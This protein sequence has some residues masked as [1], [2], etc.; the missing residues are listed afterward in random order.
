MKIKK[1]LD[2][3]KKE[4]SKLLDELTEIKEK[5]KRSEIF[6]TDIMNEKDQTL[7][8]YMK[9][10]ETNTMQ[11]NTIKRL[12]MKYRAD[13]ELQSIQK[14]RQEIEADSLQIVKEGEEYHQ[15][16]NE[17]NI[18]CIIENL[19]EANIKCND[20]IKTTNNDDV[21]QNKNISINQKYECHIAK[22]TNNERFV[23]NDEKLMEFIKSKTAISEVKDTTSDENKVSPLE[24]NRNQP[25]VNKKKI[26]YYGKDCKK[27][28]CR[29]SH[30]DYPHERVATKNN[31][32]NIYIL[33]GANM[34]TICAGFRTSV[35]DQIVVFY[36]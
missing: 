1:Q 5:L 34:T 16:N 8:E 11:S 6:F 22:E 27:N 33:E 26:C 20:E 3:S 28:D 7:N 35:K 14:L 29:Y 15:E 30:N 21:L 25:Y 10:C 24:S 12:L 2:I 36:I 18:E 31:E 4:N 9:I 13:K 23:R 19:E 17:A 32:T